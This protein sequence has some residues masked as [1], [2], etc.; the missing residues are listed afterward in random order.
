MNCIDEFVVVNFLSDD[1]M[2]I[3]TTKRA[4]RVHISDLPAHFDGASSFLAVRSRREEKQLPSKLPIV[5]ISLLS[6][7]IFP[8]GEPAILKEYIDDFSISNGENALEYLITHVSKKSG[9]DRIEELWEREGRFESK[10]IS[11][12]LLTRASVTRIEEKENKVMGKR[13]T[14]LSNVFGDNGTLS[15]I[16]K[17]YEARMPQMDMAGCVSDAL[18]NDRVQFIEADTGTGK[19]IGYLV[20]LLLAI[21]DN[22]S[23]AIIST[24]TKVL[25]D[26][27]ID[28][29]IPIVKDAIGNTSNL[30]IHLLKGRSNYL[31]LLKAM[32]SMNEGRQ[33]GLEGDVSSQMW[34]AFLERWL[35]DTK[36]GDIQSINERARDYID[37]NKLRFLTSSKEDC[38]G[39]YCPF[40]DRCFL[41]KE[42]QEA[43]NSDL[44]VVNHS[45]LL[46]EHVMRSDTDDLC[47]LP[48]ADYLV[49]D[50]AHRFADV[51]MST[52]G[53]DISYKESKNFINSLAI[54]DEKT[55]RSKGIMSECFLS[56]FGKDAKKLTRESERFD[57]V[58]K[59]ILEREDTLF[60]GIEG[61][62]TAPWKVQYND[63]AEELELTL[64]E[65]I[66]IM[67]NIEGKLDDKIENEVNTENDVVLLLR[68]K[69]VIEKLDNW[70][71]CLHLLINGEDNVWVKYIEWREG[72][73]SLHIRKIDIAEDISDIFNSYRSVILTSAT[74]NINSSFSFVT[75]QLGLDR[76]EE[77]RKARLGFSIL[78]PVF[79]YSKQALFLIPSDIEEYHY[80]EWGYERY[81]T[82]ISRILTSLIS[83]VH[84]KTL[85]LFTSYRDMNAVLS[86][87][88]NEG[89][90]I[91]VQGKDGNAQE[92]IAKFRGTGSN[93]AFGVKSLWEG[94]DL[95]GSSLEILIIVKLPFDN[96]RNPLT[97]K[98]NSLKGFGNYML[99]R[100]ILDLKQG[101]GRLIRK[102]DDK[103]IILC[104]DNR[105]L[106]KSYGNVVIHS[107]PEGMGVKVARWKKCLRTIEDFFKE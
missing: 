75:S 34:L 105:V 52:L 54:F 88:E 100:M 40:K 72:E 6:V 76:W 94:I 47:I 65:C 35:S 92:V 107:L 91:S 2:E 25:Q 69:N 33:I 67:I 3:G 8:T 84:R 73:P 1:E 9:F 96:P 62:N 37:V 23:K 12:A 30:K 15:Q 26:Q 60:R 106:K 21:R 39:R 89:Y 27:L 45:L 83:K 66:D 57:T 102:L 19:S 17:G 68:V 7:F 104:L 58:L 43:R 53:H 59:R 28:K 81:I 46:S 71:E 41:L 98:L 93:V 49:V 11:N 80:E 86:N 48:P 63:M 87:V 16:L 38:I 18:V 51:A 56:V 79:N 24:K 97:N 13:V 4:D 61:E 70:A 103:G 95:P 99:P 82:S 77:D 20:P 36:D 50:E 55:G 29:D 64:K 101:I 74:L 78:P 90:N 42:R 22:D 5:D 10:I 44:L 32:N 14:K 31:C 85:V